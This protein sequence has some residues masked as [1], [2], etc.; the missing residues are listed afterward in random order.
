MLLAEAVVQS[1][2]S[3]SIFGDR[4]DPRKRLIA[5]F[6]GELP[7]SGQPPTA[8]LRWAQ[9]VLERS[10]H[11]DRNDQVAATARLR[12]QEPRLTLR[13]ASFLA[14]HVLRDRGVSV[15]SASDGR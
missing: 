12:S 15:P 2:L 10:A 6:G 1:A 4:E 5:I 13:A 14:A 9:G 3:A 11:S 7:S 8:A